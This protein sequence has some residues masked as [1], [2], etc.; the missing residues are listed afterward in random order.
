VATVT[1]RRAAIEARPWRISGAT[2]AYSLVLLGLLA[3]VAYPLVLIIVSSFQNVRPGEQ[4]VYTLDAWR[5]ALSESDF[6][7]PLWNTLQ[8]TLA[9]EVIS[10]GVGIP[11]AWLIARADIPFARTLEFVFWIAYF[12]PSLPVTIG[13]ILLLDPHYGLLN[14]L[15]QSLPGIQ[16]APFNIYSFWGIVWA[17]VGHDAI[18]V[19]I[20]LLAPALRNIDSALEE[21]SRMSGASLLGTLWRI[22]I[23]V[24][25]PAL[26]VVGL[27]SIIN[28]L[29]TF[30]VEVVLGLPIR[31][32]VFSSQIYAYINQLNP[33]F[34][35]ATVLASIILAIIMPLVFIQRWVVGRRHYATLSG[36]FSATP[37]R[38]G[39]WRIPC[40]LLVALLACVNTVVPLSM[41]VMGSFMKLFGFF[42]LAEPWTLSNWTSVIQDSVFLTSFR[43]TLLISGS[44]AVAAVIVYGLTAYISVRTTYRLRSV[45]DFLAWMPASLPGIILGLGLLWAFLGNPLLRPLYG[46]LFAIVIAVLVTGMTI[47]VQTIKTNL[48]QIGAELEE[49][50]RIG[51][52]TFWHCARYV[53]LPLLSPVLLLVATLAFATSARDVANTALLATTTT[54]PLALLELTY[55]SG[56]KYGPATVIGVLLV[57]LTTGVALAARSFGSRQ[58]IRL[59]NATAASVAVAGETA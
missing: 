48:V 37:A 55:I 23:P 15:L 56:G 4:D 28:C 17:H 36:K 46:T 31:F 16:S 30:D 50:A 14:Q 57:L 43:N 25:A 38:L 51:G 12:L 44:A 6:A 47:G 42:N 32:Y 11:I 2:I 39:K 40:F 35:E 58:G 27:I 41:L 24:L 26:A 5:R 1:L 7:K 52:G 21:S 59:S 33:M 20:I 18:A 53:L 9:R 19:K 22:V 45:V 10:F 34:A 54:R 3:L 49:A 13:W 29:Q 8:L